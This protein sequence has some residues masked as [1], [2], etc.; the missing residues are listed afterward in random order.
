[1]AELRNAA[2]VGEFPFAFS[3]PGLRPEKEVLRS[4]PITVARNAVSARCAS[5]KRQLGKRLPSHEGLFRRRRPSIGGPTI[6]SFGCP[7]TTVRRIAVCSARRGEKGRGSEIRHR[8][9]LPPATGN[10]MRRATLHNLPV[11]IG[12]RNRGVGCAVAGWLRRLVLC[13]GANDRRNPNDEIRSLRAS[14]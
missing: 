2:K 3:G 4:A 9:P 1:M 10:G 12:V 13:R 7:R 5:I 14:D 11:R 6:A 8:Q